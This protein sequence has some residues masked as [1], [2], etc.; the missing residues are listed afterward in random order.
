MIIFITCRTHDGFTKIMFHTYIKVDSCHAFLGSQAT[1]RQCMFVSESSRV[2]WSIYFNSMSTYPEYFYVKRLGNCIH[3]MFIFR[4]FEQLFIKCIRVD[5]GVME[6]KWYSKLLRSLEN[7]SLTIR[8]S[9]VSYLR[10]LFLWGCLTPS[11]GDT[12]NIL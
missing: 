11:H 10:H 5:L 7:F 12:I 1:D 6:M 3:C 4:F 8:C 9:L 2:N